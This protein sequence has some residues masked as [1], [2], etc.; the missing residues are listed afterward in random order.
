MLIDAGPTDAGST[1]SN[2]LRSRGISSIDIV[3]AT[4][5][6][7]DHIGGMST[8]LNGFSV[9]QFIDSGYPHT[10]STYENM[11]NL[12]DKKNIPFR[13]VAKGDT[14]TLDPSVSITVLNPPSKFSDDINQNSVV[15]K[16]TYGKI[17]WLFPGDA[18]GI[19]DHADILKVPHH[20]SETGAGTLTQIDPKV[21]V[22]EVGAVNSYGHPTQMTLSR[23]ASI[24]SQIY[25][26]DMNGNVVITSDGN[27]Y[28]V[29]A[30]HSGTTS[31]ISTSTASEYTTTAIPLTTSPTTTR[32]TIPTIISTTIHT[33]VPT[34]VPVAPSCTVNYETGTCPVGKCWVRD[35]CR[36]SG[37]HVNGYC[38][39]C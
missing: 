34:I 19:T 12:I 17:T 28:S 3:V 9:K 4:H 10:T 39:K 20:G 31:V 22:I 14:I 36:A 25:R 6:H 5:P 2:Y 15:L 1:V 11:L 38:R 30:D 13:T 37:T 16:M 35:Y 29:S 33:A 21:S 8:I 32:T 26:T 24:G 7:E 23:L 27:T 18:G